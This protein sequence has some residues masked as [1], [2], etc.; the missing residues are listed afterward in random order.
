MPPK[1]GLLSTGDPKNGYSNL[2]DSDRAEGNGQ[3]DAEAGAA[4]SGT[5]A[6]RAAFGKH[7]SMSKTIDQT[8]FERATNF[9]KDYK[10]PNA[11]SPRKQALAC[12]LKY[13][14][15]PLIVI[16]MFYIWLGKR[17][18]AIYQVLPV[19]VVK[20]IFGVGLCFFGGVY[21]ETIAAAEAFRSFGGQA[22]W[23]ELCIVWEEAKLAH[24]ATEEDEKKE[25]E[26][27]VDVSQMSANELINHKA[28]V[29]MAAVKDPERLMKA[30]Q[31]LFS[32]Y[33]SV[34]ATLKFQFAK[35]VALA[36]GIASML[37]LPLVRCF[38]PILAPAMGEEIQHWIPAIIG[39]VIKVIAVVVA[40]LI[41]SII[42]A[43]YSGLRGGQI[44][45]VALIN[46][47]GEN[48]FMDKCPDWLAKKP[49]DAN[50]SYL[51]EAI[52]YPLAAFGFAWQLMHGMEPS[53]PWNIVLFPLTIVKWILRWQIF[54]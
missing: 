8:S 4:E 27:G 47:L 24:A 7:K 17:L 33:L 14:V 16:I 2:P 31:F 35:T 19:N 10:D 53:F 6:K 39:T 1:G 13:L 30:V 23:E 20:M 48:G 28:K 50:E 40:S 25:K 18:Y 54:T 51:D 12:F 41:Q 46:M 3:K 26:N 34:I 11:D 49:F 37:E 9:I 38:G 22:L 36:L 44:F 43:F 15:K 45:S 29:A 21:F 52:G 32:A 5:D 42:S